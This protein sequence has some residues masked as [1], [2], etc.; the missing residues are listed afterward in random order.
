MY[1]SG[2][3]HL[4]KTRPFHSLPAIVQHA[5]VCPTGI[6]IAWSLSLTL[7][8][9][10]ARVFQAHVER[11]Q[12]LQGRGLARLVEIPVDHD[13]G[14][15]RQRQLQLH[16]HATLVVQRAD[17]REQPAVARE[18]RKRR[19]L[20]RLARDL[21]DVVAHVDLLAKL[22]RLG[23]REDARAARDDE[24]PGRLV[25]DHHQIQLVRR[26]PCDQWKSLQCTRVW[27]QH[28]AYVP[29]NSIA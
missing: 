16:V 14:L 13:L 28:E 18:L 25:D 4:V 11:G 23:L 12:V 17:V 26:L 22:E 2:Y 8:L 3:L 9:D 20:G 21:D 1:A 10:I 5:S 29:I 7:A 27:I 24:L 6:I 15:V 19:D